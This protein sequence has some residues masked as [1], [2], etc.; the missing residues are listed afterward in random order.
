MRVRRVPSDLLAARHEI[1]L[2]V[3]ILK[4]ALTISEQEVLAKLLDDA[5]AFLLN[6]REAMERAPCDTEA[7]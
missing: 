7:P 1:I 5:S 3:D 2:A 4:T 6:A